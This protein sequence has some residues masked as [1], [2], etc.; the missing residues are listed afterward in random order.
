MFR[1]KIE[2]GMIKLSNKEMYFPDGRFVTISEIMDTV[3]SEEI[4]R[5]NGIVEGL[6]DECR[7]MHKKGEN[8]SKE[9]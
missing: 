4:S 6:C 8:L 1:M 9:W 2:E 5:E 7:Q 3:M